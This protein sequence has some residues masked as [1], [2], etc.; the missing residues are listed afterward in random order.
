MNEEA[1]KYNHKNNPIAGAVVVFFILLFVFSKWGPAIPFSV[2]SQTKGEPMIVTGEGKSVVVPDIAKVN[3]GIETSG[4]NLKQ[5]QGDVNQ[6]SL[7]LVSALKSLGVEERD[8]KTTSYNI[9]PESDYSQRPPK[10]TGY[11]VSIDY[12]VTVKNI[13]KVN[14]IL[15]AVTNKGANLVGGVSFDL[16]DDAKKKAMDTAR[17]DAVE[18]AKD[19]AESL[20]KASGVTLGKI[21]NVTESSSNGLTRYAVPMAGGSMMDSK[22]ANPEVTPGTT[23]INL[24]VSLSYEVR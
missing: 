15:V 18:K 5:V 9:Y 17:T 21:I 20:A 3:V 13:D 24:T 23:E 8:I 1:S 12:V 14:D 10:I 16:S 4:Q 11:R 7:K 6:K 2:L 19:N 22:V